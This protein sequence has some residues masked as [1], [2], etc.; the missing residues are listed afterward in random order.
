MTGCTGAVNG[1]LQGMHMGWQGKTRAVTGKDRGFSYGQGFLEP[2][3]YT[4]GRGRR[5][6]YAMSFSHFNIK[7]NTDDEVWIHADGIHEQYFYGGE[8]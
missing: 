4:D 1:G 7:M 8:L 2:V 6:G 5:V 3:V